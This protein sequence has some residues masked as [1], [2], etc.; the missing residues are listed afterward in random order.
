MSVTKLPQSQSNILLD[1]YQNGRYDDAEKLAILLT[2][3]FPHDQFSWKVLGATLKKKGKVS[4]SLVASQK[5]VNINPQDV[6]AHS[7]LGNTLHE[8]GK[9][10]EAQA[11]YRQAVIIN[12]DYA[13]GHNNLGNTLKE[14]GRLQEAQAS[15]RQAVI[16]NPDY[17]IAHN[18]L[19]VIL[20]ELGRLQE[21]HA[22]YKQA[23][24]INSDYANAHNNLG[25]ILQKL[26]KFQEAQAS[27]RQ[28][29]RINPDYAIAHN[30][31][32]NSLKELGKYQAAES[33]YKQA[34]TINPDYSEAYYNLGVLYLDMARNFKELKQI[35]EAVKYF[36]EAL[37][38]HPEDSFGA[39]LELVR[40]GHKN[41]PDKTPLN[42]M[43][44]FYKIKSK[45]YELNE[46]KK[47]NGHLLIK[48]AFKATYNKQDKLDILDLGC[49]SGS[50]AG[51]LRPYAKNL[52][53]VDLSP[54]MLHIAEKT[55]LY[56]SLHQDDLLKYLSKITIQYDKVL[57]AAVMVHFSK[58]ENVFSLVSDRLK[59][60]GE[61]IFSIFEGTQKD[62]ELNSSFF[63]EHSSDYIASL[64]NQH[65]L[66]IVYKQQG[67]HEYHKEIPVS[68][69]IY[70]LQKSK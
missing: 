54:D 69:L 55:Q 49:G 63:Y 22:S 30:N 64:A 25:V 18:N 61:F 7:N 68:G 29:V 66:K 40:L 67:V 9:F 42:Y 59:I 60:K 24:T 53:G 1:H 56:D 21:A 58:L 65:K 23:V 15:Y 4:E 41:M 19:G 39:T 46:D 3:Q 8:L 43:Q 36:K 47:Y 70:V 12:P 62:I 6:E 52:Y 27:Y 38:V 50:L 33:S 28:A 20:Q 44:G 57:A 16:I 11:S 31:L 13:I 10:E 48:N 2:E 34:I 32:G 17:A 45:S 51:F 14:L 35:N 5:A 37:K 26:G